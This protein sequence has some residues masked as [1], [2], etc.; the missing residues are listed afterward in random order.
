VLRSN[1]G[2]TYGEG[3]IAPPDRIGFWEGDNT[4]GWNGT[5]FTQ[6][7]FEIPAPSGLAMVGLAV[8]VA[9]RRRRR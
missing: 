9:A 6:Q 3:T 5:Q 2:A 1:G 4:A 8:A 7:I